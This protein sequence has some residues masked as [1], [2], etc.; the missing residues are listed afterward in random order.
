MILSVIIPAYNVEQTL[1]RC[2]ES[3]VSQ[4]VEDMEVII[5]NDG[6]RDGTE[7]TAKDLAEE[8]DCVKLITQPNGGLSDARN[9]GINIAQGE[10][11]TFVD[12]DD[13]L[14][15]DVYPSLIALLDENSGCD[16]LE[17]SFMQISEEEGLSCTTLPQNTYT[18]FRD[19]WLHGHAYRHTYAWNKIFRRKIFF[20]GEHPLLRFAKGKV[21]EDI[22]F[23]SELLR[24]KPRIMTVPT[25][26][27]IYRKNPKGITCTAGGKE[28]AQLLEAHI[29]I[30]KS[31]GL[32]FMQENRSKRRLP[33]EEEECYM[34]AAN[35]QIYVCRQTGAKPILPSAIPTIRLRDLRSPKKLIKKLLLRMGG[36]EKLCH[37]QDTFQPTLTS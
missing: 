1:R 8:F 16:V 18:D 4:K 17:Y 7:V 2:V 13:Y 9:S 10:Y 12:S 6:S 24:L 21:F 31:L 27:Y 22:F 29:R 37:C 5:V 3:V 30:A 11:I 20:E 19:Y 23:M 34:A 26:N 25:G 15:G 33:Q 35:I 28:L 14:S 32:S 36:I